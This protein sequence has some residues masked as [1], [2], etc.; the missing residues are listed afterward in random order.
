MKKLFL[1][2]LILASNLFSQGWNDIVTVQEIEVPNIT[3]IFANSSGIHILIRDATDGDII[4]YNLN[5]AGIVDEGK[6][7][8]LEANG[9]FPNIVGTNDI[10]YAIYKTG[11]NIRVRY[12]TDNGS[13][14]LTNIVDKPTTAN[15]CNGVDAVYEPNYGVHIVWATQDGGSSGFETYYRRLAPDNSWPEYKNVTDDNAAQYGGNPSVVVSP[16]CVHVS[17]NTDATTTNY[18]T[19]NVKTR[20]KY[21]GSWQDPQPV[22]PVSGTDE[23]SVDERLMV[24]GDYLYLFYNQDSSPNHLGY[25]IRSLSSTEWSDF[26]TIE[27]GSLFYYKDAFEVTKTS[28]S[29]IHLIYKKYIQ[30]QGWVYSYTYFNGSAWSEPY[31]FDNNA[32]AS[33]QIGLSSVSNDLFCTWV[34]GEISNLRYRQ[35]D[36]VPVTPLAFAGTNY[37]N[38]PKLTWTKVEPDI[39]YFE[40]Y[41][42]IVSDPKN[43][44]SWNLLTTTSNTSFVDYGVTMGGSE[45]GE[46]NYKIR[47]K[48]YSDNFSP[49]TGIITFG[50]S[51]LNK[52]AIGKEVNEYK[53]FNN[54]PN[55]FNPSTKISY[56]IKEEGLV[57]LKVYDV[58]GKEVATLVNENKS[59]GNYEAEFNASQLP[60]GMYIY[61]LKVGSFSDVKKMLLTK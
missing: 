47:S 54:Y 48:D 5:S 51:G 40:I 39:E 23:H 59:G 24:L 31:S 46:V 15:Y 3:D 57:S 8:T 12:S 34:N 60:S 28:N 16:N 4:Y 30:Y 27:S 58:L 36:A 2:I 6:T 20:D 7:E 61:K 19:G 55:P 11:N 56:S 37:E 29:N 44:G 53:L 33:R 10:I 13:N 18:G 9:D 22:V 1:L 42:Q 21:Y 50:Y 49:Y 14:W 45:T 17:F 26:T 35:Y 41:W 43:P 38:H 32:L 25:K 52:I